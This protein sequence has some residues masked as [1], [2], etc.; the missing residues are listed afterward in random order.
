MDAPRFI[1]EL[2]RRRVFRV[3]AA[4]AIVGFAVAEGLDLL[5]PRLGVP[6]WTVTALIVALLAGF[7]IALVMAWAL[8]VGPG[9]IRVTEPVA[10]HGGGGS[11]STWPGKVGYLAVFALGVLLSWGGW[12]TMGWI[13]ADGGET[14]TSVRSLA[15]LPFSALSDDSGDHWMAQGLHDQLITE[16]AQLSGLDRV[17]SRTSVLRYA[18]NPPGITEI[19]QVL[20]VDAII[21]G[22]IL[23]S[24][25][26]IRINV[27][28]IAG[29]TDDHLWARDYERAREDALDLVKSVA[30]DIAAELRLELNATDEARFEVERSVNPAAQEAYFRGRAYLEERTREGGMRA[31]EQFQRAIDLDPE[32]GQAY[33]GMASYHALGGGDG[34]MAMVEEFARRALDLDP[35]LAEAYAAMGFSHLFKDQAWDEAEEHFRTA[36]RLQPGFTTGWQWGSELLAGRGKREEAVEWIRRAR[37]LD[38]FSGIIAWSELRILHLTGRF[39]ECVSANERYEVDFADYSRP[40]NREF[41]LLGAGR[42]SEVAGHLEAPDSIQEAVSAG[43]IRDFWVWLDQVPEWRGSWVVLAQLNQNDEFFES[44]DKVWERYGGLGLNLAYYVADPLLA[45]LR[46]DPRWEGVLLPR[47]GLTRWPG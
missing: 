24:E 12:L 36:V 6:D 22:S 30:Q 43:R 41:C 5:L 28:L 40:G 17:I 23:S 45:P 31:A 47:V 16:L 4:Y 1:S 35:G 21:E 19:A 9:G 42:Y 15:V 18:E 2:K 29:K 46:H 26:R 34:D 44:F 37:K 27:Q 14:V 3:A 13:R 39:E 25:D 11:T 32:Y 33:A 7:P 10:D 38:P 8:E 20:N